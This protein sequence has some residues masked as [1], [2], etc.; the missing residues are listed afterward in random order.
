MSH[1]PKLL[2]S[3]LEKQG[4]EFLSQFSDYSSLKS[5]IEDSPAATNNIEEDEWLGFSEVPSSHE[6]PTRSSGKGFLNHLLHRKLNN[7]SHRT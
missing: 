1:S 7:T 4:Q 5:K 6:I 3:L 2:L